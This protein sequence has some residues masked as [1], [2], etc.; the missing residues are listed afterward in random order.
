[1]VAEPSV[2]NDDNLSNVRR[3]KLVD[4]SGARKGNI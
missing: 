3:G 4:I 1:V 2:M